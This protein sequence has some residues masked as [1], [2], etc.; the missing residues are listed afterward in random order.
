M[1]LK[2]ENLKDK[3]TSIRKDIE[4]TINKNLVET[5][6]QHKGENE[7]L[8]DKVKLLETENKILKDYIATKQ[9]LIDSLLQYKN[10]LITQQERLTT[11]L[12]T[13]TSEN[14]SKGRSKDVIQTE[15]NIR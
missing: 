8:N 10:L 11:E 12:V 15:N 13:P 4:P 6:N 1:V 5:I 3:I 2:I 14:S 7:K 9:K